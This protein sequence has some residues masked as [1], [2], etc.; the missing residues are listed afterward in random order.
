[1]GV[2][3]HAAL[4]RLVTL[5]NGLA[6]GSQLIRATQL[7]HHVLRGMPLPTSDVFIVPSSP[8]SG[9]GTPNWSDSFGG[10]TLL[11]PPES[12]SNDRLAFF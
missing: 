8:T 4:Q 10:N 3:G 6:L 1:M 9:H 2:R 11:A 7:A 12:E 5:L